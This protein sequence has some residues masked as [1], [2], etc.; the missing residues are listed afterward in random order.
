MGSNGLEHQ[1]GMEGACNS[2]LYSSGLLL[3]SALA[4][5]DMGRAAPSPCSTYYSEEVGA[6]VTTPLSSSA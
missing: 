6:G 1:A 5:V 4:C 3:L 2:F